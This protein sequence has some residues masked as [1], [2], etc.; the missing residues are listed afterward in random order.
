MGDTKKNL[1]LT[2]NIDAGT[3][4][5]NQNMAN[6]IPGSPEWGNSVNSGSLP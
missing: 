5:P 6:P 1:H 2:P 4:K 3:G